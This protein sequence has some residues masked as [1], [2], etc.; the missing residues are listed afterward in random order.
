[1]HFDIEAVDTG[2]PLDARAY[3][4]SRLFSAL[5]EPG[6]AVF[7]V[8]GVVSAAGAD[9]I[10]CRIRVLLRAGGEILVERRGPQLYMT[11][12]RVAEAAAAA[13]GPRIGEIV[14]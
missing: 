4:E 3:L 10:R 7:A 11:I 1:M 5:S 6:P 2:L 9:H 8:S 13:L 12:D 14:A